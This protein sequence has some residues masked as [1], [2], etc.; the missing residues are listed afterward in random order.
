MRT[1]SIPNAALIVLLLFAGPVLAQGLSPKEVAAAYHEPRPYILVQ[2]VQGATTLSRLA[3]TEPCTT[4]MRMATSNIRRNS[5]E[6]CSPPCNR[7]ADRRRTLRVRRP[8]AVRHPLAPETSATRR[9]L[10]RSSASSRSPRHADASREGE[11]P[12]EPRARNDAVWQSR[13]GRSLA[14]PVDLNPSF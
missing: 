5:C 7:P 10:P 6:T 8:D 12:A 9:T 11:A 2:G 4:R 1:H 14:L 3:S 13:R